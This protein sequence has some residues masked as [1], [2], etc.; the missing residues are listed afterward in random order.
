MAT[1]SGVK[2][3]KHHTKISKQN[4]SDTV[5][6]TLEILTKIHEQHLL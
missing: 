4:V 1:N 3:F 5:S 2:Q 6:G